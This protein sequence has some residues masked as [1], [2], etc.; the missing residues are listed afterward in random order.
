MH[1]ASTASPT[2][3]PAVV[4]RSKVIGDMD[5][6]EHRIPQEGRVSLTVSDRQIDLRLV[7]IPSVWGE[8]VVMRVLDKSQS[9]RSLPELGLR[10]R[11]PWSASHVRTA[12]PTASSSSPGPT[13]AGQDDH[14]VLDV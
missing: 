13:G 5:I 6:T 11:H 14:P 9:L 1:E 8:T 12:S 10:V 2:I 7:T 4:S 3:A